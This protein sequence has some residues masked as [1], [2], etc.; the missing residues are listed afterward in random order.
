MKTRYTTNRTRGFTWV[1]LLVVIGVVALLA[2]LLLPALAAAKRKAQRI[3]CVNYLMQTGMS[4][5]I[6]E[7]DNFGKYPMQVI[8][9]NS[10][11]MKLITNGSA[12]V[13]WR[14]MSNELSTPFILHCPADTR[15]VAATNFATGFSNANISYFFSLDAFESYPQMILDGDDNL[16]VDGVRVKPGILNLWTNNI[17][18]TKER[19]RGNGNIGM[20]DGSV[21]QTTSAG[22]NSAVVSSTSGVPTNNVPNRWVIP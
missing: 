12:Y 2:A 9:T 18:W 15:R 8:L 14:T 4:F 1:E 7:G 20:A 16:I 13:L 17:A 22:L 10:E 3:H 5:R 6:F 21:Q 11:T 19:H